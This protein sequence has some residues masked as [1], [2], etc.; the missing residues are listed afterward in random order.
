MVGTKSNF[1]SSTKND[2]TA[3]SENDTIAW[4]S[5]SIFNQ[6]QKR[7]LR[8]ESKTIKHMLIFK[9]TA[10]TFHLNKFILTTTKIISK[11]VVKWTSVHK[12]VNRHMSSI[13]VKANIISKIWRKSAHS[14]NNMKYQVLKYVISHPTANITI[15]QDT[16][17][18]FKHTFIG[19]RR[20]WNAKMSLRS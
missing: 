2:D 15:S 4:L 17:I 13:R 12:H 11:T 16:S 18:L 8:S 9:L 6:E 5:K 20:R 10:A 7:T 1:L 14:I 19:C 3:A